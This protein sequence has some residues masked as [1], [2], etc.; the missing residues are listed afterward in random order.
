MNNLNKFTKVKTSNLSEKFYSFIVV[1]V[2]WL[3]QIGLSHRKIRYVSTWKRK[4]KPFTNNFTKMFKIRKWKL[5][6]LT[7]NAWLGWHAKQC[8]ASTPTFNTIYSMIIILCNF[9]IMLK[10][11]CNLNMLMVMWPAA[12]IRFSH[13]V[14]LRIWMLNKCYWNKIE[15]ATFQLFQFYCI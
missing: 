7:Q 6:Y 9:T 12:D 10:T 2:P 14:I 8:N 15:Y 13:S 4:K 1:A 5:V 11:I 3:N